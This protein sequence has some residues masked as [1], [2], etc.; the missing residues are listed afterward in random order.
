MIGPDI[1]RMQIEWNK[2][3]RRILRIP[4][5]THT[6]LLPLLINADTFL[7]LFRKR[8]ARFV[9]SFWQDITHMVF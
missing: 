9:N 3:V 2:A 4:Y 6:N 1:D 7:V 5:Q 8:I